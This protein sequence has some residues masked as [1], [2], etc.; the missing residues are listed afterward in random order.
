MTKPPAPASDR[1]YT[2]GRV[3][4]ITVTVVAILGVAWLLVELSGFLMLIFGALV[5]A[6]IFDAVT[7]RVSMLTRMKRGYSLALSVLAVLAIFAG[8]FALFGTQLAGEFDTIRDS[9]PPAVEQVRM[10]LDR[11]GLGEPARDL[12]DQGSS[13]IS[14]L[15]A[16]AGGYALTAG[17]GIANLVLVFVAAIFLASD[18]A[19]YRRGLLLLMPRRAEAPVAA[20]LDDASRGLRGWMIGQAVSSLVVALLTWVGL[21]ALGV[22]ASGGL[23]LIAGLLDVI[24]M[25]GP[26][27]AGVPAVLLAFTVSPATALWTIGLF[28]LIQQLQGNFLQPMIQKQA[29]N[30]PPAVLLFA[31]V[32]AGLLFGF[33]GVLLAAPLTVVIYVLVQRLYVRTLLGKE[34]E[35]A[36]QD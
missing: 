30:V 9:I 17:S 2:I 4:A 7:R 21:A 25:I 27:I 13:D 34:I 16:R 3:A 28:L 26:I 23:G 33:L 8:A 18:P 1:S 36:G 32:A 14:A 20:A 12:L 11:I 15:A 22:P 6:A 29:V 10:F 19:V 24:P 5:L 31:V 35:I